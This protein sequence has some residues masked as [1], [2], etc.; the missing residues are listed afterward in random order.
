MVQSTRRRG[1]SSLFRLPT[2]VTTALVFV[3]PRLSEAQPRAS[4]EVRGAPA[5]TS[6][7]LASGSGSIGVGATSRSG[8]DTAF[9]GH[10]VLFT[11][12]ASLSGAAGTMTNPGVW[13]SGTF[14]WGVMGEF[15]FSG[16]AWDTSSMLVS[17]LYRGRA[18][19]LLGHFPRRLGPLS[20]GF[21]AFVG[22]GHTS[23]G[24][25]PSS[26]AVVMTTGTCGDGVPL[27]RTVARYLDRS[28]DMFSTPNYSSHPL[29]AGVAALAQLRLGAFVGSIWSVVTYQW[30]MSG[31]GGAYTPW[32]A[33][34]FGQ[35]RVLLSVGARG[36]LGG[37]RLGIEG[38][39]EAGTGVQS[40]GGGARMTVGFA[41]SVGD[42]F[43]DL[44]AGRDPHGPWQ[45][46]QATV[47]TGGISITLP[48]QGLRLP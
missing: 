15:G 19:F 37:V 10:G 24:V 47:V 38:S 1:Q 16:R 14:A 3:V 7:P 39:L 5:S 46:A 6:A 27:D 22:G 8:G 45:L 13:G 26:C 21:L 17:P 41:R 12:T 42:L 23:N 2:I 44:H 34:A 4:P 33:E 43:I 29:E 31:V 35:H 11:V 36:D 25:G 18:W 9:D 48:S 32:E 28:P 30:H 20:P 40:V